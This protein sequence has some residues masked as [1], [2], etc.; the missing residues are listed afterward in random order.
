MRTRDSLE[1][2]IALKEMEVVPLILEVESSNLGTDVDES[3]ELANGSSVLVSIDEDVNMVDDASAVLRLSD[4]R[5]AV[6]VTEAVDVTKLV[7]IATEG[8]VVGD[9]IEEELSI[10]GDEDVQGG[11]DEDI[12]EDDVMMKVEGVI[13][14]DEDTTAD[15]EAPVSIEKRLL[16]L[17]TRVSELGVELAV[18]VDIVII[19]EIEEAVLSLCRLCVLEL[20]LMLVLMLL[21]KR[22]APSSSDVS[23]VVLDV[24][25]TVVA[26]VSELYSE[27]G[28]LVADASGLWETE[29]EGL[30]DVDSVSILVVTEFDS[31]NP[32]EFEKLALV[33]SSLT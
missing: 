20:D 13:I 23:L 24:V 15:D 32:N 2:I 10:K 17:D 22:V 4:I 27:F 33:P 28:I 12:E 19:E 3:M 8:D 6:V 26:S 31:L 16:L 11:E 14:V 29:V 18:K 7:D 1:L 30:A 9:D 5:E 25:L 21:D